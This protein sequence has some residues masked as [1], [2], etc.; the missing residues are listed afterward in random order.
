MRVNSSPDNRERS[1]Q[2]HFQIETLVVPSRGENYEFA[3]QLMI[4]TAD[5]QPFPVRINEQTARKSPE[6]RQITNL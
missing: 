5:A 3:A 1:S 6:F 4:L 2:V